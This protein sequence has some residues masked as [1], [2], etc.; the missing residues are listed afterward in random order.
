M[1]RLNTHVHVQHPERGTVVFGP[2]DPVPDWAAE[3]ITNPDVWD[4]APD[5]ED[6]EVATEP[7]DVSDTEPSD[8]SGDGPAET[9]DTEETDEPEDVGG[10]PSPPPRNGPGSTRDAWFAYA[11]K[12]LELDIADDADRDDIMAAVDA[13]S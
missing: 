12:V 5:V 10:Q 11:T 2:D 13:A 7:S 6:D 3:A 4:D 8:G 9:S 1:A